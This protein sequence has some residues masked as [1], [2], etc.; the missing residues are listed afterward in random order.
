MSQKDGLVLAD[1]YTSVRLFIWGGS[2][3]R[4]KSYIARIALPISFE[5]ANDDAGAYTSISIFAQSRCNVTDGPKGT[6]FW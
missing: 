6:W 1:T 4:D 2:L 3:P 5:L